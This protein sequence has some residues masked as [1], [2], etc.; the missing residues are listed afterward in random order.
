MKSLKLMK[1]FASVT[2]AAMMTV[3]LSSAPLA[4]ETEETAPSD[5]PAGD[6]VKLGLMIARNGQSPAGDDWEILADIF[7]DVINNRHEDLSLPFAADEGLPNLGGAKVEFVTGEQ[8]DTQTAVRIADQLI[9][10]E[11]VVGLFGHFT[12]TTT[13]AAMVSAEKNSVPLLSEGTS[14]SLL[15]AGYDYWLRSFGGDDFYV[16]SS[17]E[18]IDSV[19]ESAGDITTIALCSENSDFGTGIASLEKAAAEEHGYEVVENVFYDSADRDI[20][21]KVRL[22]K[23]ADADVVMMSSYAADA[24]AFMEEFKAQDYFPKMLLGQRGGFMS[25]GFGKTLGKDADTVLTTARWSDSMDNEASRQIAK[26]YEEKTGSALLGDVLVDVWNGVLLAVAINQAG[27]TDSAQV[28]DVFAKGLDLD[29]ALD[30]MALEGY[31]YGETGENADHACVIVQYA[32]GS[33]SPVYPEDKAVAGLTY[34]SV[35]WSER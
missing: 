6:T 34:P 18:F 21:S 15:N 20:S 26:L 27:T 8:I 30:P 3:C 31:S 25:S 2:L 32:D 19:K 9:Q 10:E 14:M 16:E 28:R 22:L 5:A 4:A 29:P 12:S 11:G 17:M 23:E 13:A 7:E 24:L 1:Q 35:T 33:L